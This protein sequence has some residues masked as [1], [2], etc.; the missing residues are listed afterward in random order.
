M[1]LMHRDISKKIISPKYE[2][3]GP[4]YCQL[5]NKDLY[6]ENIYLIVDRNYKIN[7]QL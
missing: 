2:V 4:R 6:V 1:K 5:T 7:I 3:N